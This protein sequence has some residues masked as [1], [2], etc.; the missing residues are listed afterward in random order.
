MEMISITENIKQK[1]KQYG[2]VNVVIA[3]ATCSG[4]STLANQ[5]LTNF[6]GEVPVT[7]VKQDDYFKDISEIPKVAQGYLTDSINAFHT[8]EFKQDVEQLLTT[9]ETF[10][11]R[12]DVSQNIRI[13]KDVRVQSGVINIFEGLHTIILLRSIE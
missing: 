3:G 11:P 1:I 4:K 7:V 5:L 8:Y 13:A 2:V 9:G 12:Y 6:E 10:I